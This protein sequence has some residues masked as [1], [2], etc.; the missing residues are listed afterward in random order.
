V[1]ARSRPTSQ[2]GYQG[3]RPAVRWRSD[4]WGLRV[5]GR[6]QVMT[7]YRARVK[8]RE[9]MGLASARLWAEEQVSA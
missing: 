8:G 2:W 9:N 6:D 7:L 4:K 1:T 3:A 5:S